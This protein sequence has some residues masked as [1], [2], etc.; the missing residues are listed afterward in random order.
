[1][2]NAGYSS[3]SLRRFSAFLQRAERS[4]IFFQAMWFDLV[5]LN[6]PSF[7]QNLQREGLSTSARQIV[8]IINLEKRRV[9]EE[10]IVIG[11]LGQGCAMAIVVLLSLGH[12]LGGLVGTSGYLPFWFELEDATAQDS[13][14]EVED[15]DDDQDVF[16]RATVSNREGQHAAN[17]LEMADYDVEW[18]VYLQAVGQPVPYELDHIV[19]FI[20][21]K[22]GL[23]PYNYD[24]M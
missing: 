16:W 1:M 23:A 3:E 14:D 22:V 9:P 12:R 15:D 18:M 20:H 8:S 13:S 17:A 19:S 21:F 6:D 4:T 5:R 10:N 11:G 7:R 2:G 24:Y